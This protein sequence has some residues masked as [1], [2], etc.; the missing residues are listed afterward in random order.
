MGHA[1]T[2]NNSH[3]GGRG[4]ILVSLSDD[5]KLILIER[6]KMESSKGPGP[7]RLTLDPRPQDYIP[8]SARRSQNATNPN[9][10]TAMKLAT[11][12]FSLALGFRP[13]PNVCV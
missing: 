13:S 12:L 1:P 7:R 4:Y 5:V 6:W 11:K 2:E 9:T 3:F 10:I 8:N